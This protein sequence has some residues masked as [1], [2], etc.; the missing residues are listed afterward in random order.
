MP[1]PRT[2]PSSSS[3]LRN[4]K[5]PQLGGNANGRCRLLAHFFPADLRGRTRPLMKEEETKD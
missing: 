4:S 2:E 1:K 5:I 3:Q